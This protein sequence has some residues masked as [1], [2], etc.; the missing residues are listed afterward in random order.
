MNDSSIGVRYAKALFELAKENKLTN[1]VLSDLNSLDELYHVV[2]EF[3][4]LVNSPVIQASDKLSI[5]EMSVK[6]AFS[7]LTFRFLELLINNKREG[8]LPAVVRKFKKLFRED[9]GIVSATFTTVSLTSSQTLEHL[10]ELLVD[11]LKTAVDLTN[12]TDPD[13]IGGYTLRIEDRQLDASVASQLKKIKREL[14]ST[15]MN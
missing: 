8:Y 2:D 13:L 15:N 4:E 3:K 6:D 5:F 14:E 12:E 9:Q 10:K 11:Q 1:E 7:P